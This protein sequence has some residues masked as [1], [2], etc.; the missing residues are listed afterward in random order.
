MAQYQVGNEIFEIDDAVPEAEAIEAINQILAQPR[1]SALQFSYDSARQMAGAGLETIGDLSEKYF[2]GDL[3]ISEYG[4]DLRQRAADDIAKGRYQREFEGSFSDQKSIGDAAGW[5]L[6]GIQENAVS[7]GAALAGGA[8]AAATA[9]LSLPAAAVIGGI[10]T[11]GSAILGT[12]ET[13]LEMR[14]KTGEVNEEL[15]LGTG[16][17]IGLLDR[18]GAGKVFSK[19]QLAD[20]TVGQLYEEL[21]KKGY[22]R[23]AEEFGKEVGKRAT[24]EGITEAT[25]EGAIVGATAAT[26]GEYTAGEV[27]DR[28]LDAGVIG[29]GQAGAISAPVQAGKM[30]VSGTQV[31]QHM[32]NMDKQAELLR[33]IGMETDNPAVI[34]AANQL[35]IAVEAARNGDLTFLKEIADAEQ[36]ADV[37]PVDES[38]RESRAQASF[39]A[40]LQSIAEDGDALTGKPLDLQDVNP[41]SEG[42][43]RKA[44]ETAHGQIAGQIAELVKIL[45]KQL[46]P[47]QADTLNEL[48]DR[49][50]VKQALKLSRNKVKKS[51]PTSAFEQLGEL[52]A[53][54]REGDILRNLVL[55]SMELT[56][57]HNNGYVGGLSGFVDK[58]ANPFAT[59]GSYDGKSQMAN[60]VRLA[61]TAVA[62]TA[63]G[64]ITLLAQLGLVGGSRAIDALSG[65]R[66]SAV[67][68][69]VRD[70]IGNTRLGVNPTLPSLFEQEKSLQKSQ[71][72]RAMLLEALRANIELDPA[73][74]PEFAILKTANEAIQTY[75][76]TSVPL[77]AQDIN[78]A[79]EAL[80]ASLGEEY[81]PF[82]DAIRNRQVGDFIEN[83]HM[84]LLTDMIVTMK[85][86]AAR[87]AQQNQDLTV[88]AETRTLNQAA[89]EA[90]KLENQAFVQQIRD[91]LNADKKASAVVKGRIMT[92]LDEFGRNLG[93]DPVKSIDQEIKKIT[94]GE[95]PVPQDMV[96][97][98]LTPYRNRVKRQQQQAAAADKLAADIEGK[99]KKNEVFDPEAGMLVDNT[100]FDPIDLGEETAATI[101]PIYPTAD[102]VPPVQVKKKVD[103]IRWL[104]ENLY[105]KHYGT[106]N[107]IE[108][109]PANVVVVGRK[110]A[111][112]ALKAL[113][114]D[115][116]AIGWYDRTLKDAKAVMTLLDP[117]LGPRSNNPDNELAFDFALAVTSNGTAV[118]QNFEYAYKAYQTWQKTGFM[119][120]NWNLGGERMNAMRNAFAFY[121][122]YT[123]LYNRG[124]ITL[125]IN[126]FFNKE[127]TRGELTAFVDEF[128]AT[129]NTNVTVPTKDA[130]DTIVNGSYILGPKIGQGF[131]QN[132]RGNYDNLTADMWWMRMWNRQIGRPFEPEKSEKD[133]KKNRDII[134]RE[135]KASKGNDRKLVNE[136]LK[137]IGETRDGLYNSAERID[138]LTNELHRVW[139]RYYARHKKET[140]RNPDKPQLWKTVGTHF[141]NMGDSVRDM[142]GDNA[143][144]KFM[145]EATREAIRLMKTTGVDISVAD[146]QAL[147]WYPEKR[148]LKM[149]GVKPGQGDDNDYL[150]AAIA[151]AKKEGFTNDQIEEALGASVRG[152]TSNANRTGPEGQDG[153]FLNSPDQ[154]DPGQGQGEF[155]FSQ[156]I[157]ASATDQSNRPN[158]NVTIPTPHEVKEEAELASALFE[159][160]KPGSP[161][162]FGVDNAK[163]IQRLIEAFGIHLDLYKSQSKMFQEQQTSGSGTMGIYNP[164]MNQG[165]GRMGVMEPGF[166]RRKADIFGDKRYQQTETSFLTTLLHELSHHIESRATELSYDEFMSG[167]S[168]KTP[169]SG[170]SAR[171]GLYYE[172][173]FIPTSFRD[174]I[175]N[176]VNLA[177]KDSNTDDVV[178][179][180][181]GSLPTVTVNKARAKKISAELDDL[182]TNTEFFFRNR[183]ELS[184]EFVR[185]SGDIN[186]GMAK[187]MKSF[188][189]AKAKAERDGLDFNFKDRDVYEQQARRDRERFIRTYIRDPGETAVDPL[190]VYLGN[191]QLAKEVM[192][193]TTKL[194]REFLNDSDL[195][196][197]I[198]TFYSTP[199]ATAVAAALALLAVNGP[200]GEEEEPM[201]PMSGSPATGML[202]I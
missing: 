91:E 93:T 190:W 46:D 76:G 25:Q 102:A 149:L 6:Q 189:D 87:R 194:I 19:S 63:T 186:R 200:G 125:S 58:F 162:E 131:Y 98:Y 35:N 123:D 128:N 118:L 78:D 70:N 179:R 196:K 99:G 62:G 117:T 79:N 84:A 110:M 197:G 191:P 83:E 34:D 85:R 74:G 95:T 160:G 50:D 151:L 5:V 148:L 61:G 22:R 161:Y 56:R 146:F 41:N 42:G 7:G 139:N 174:L 199:L 119:P 143:D 152:R 133:M 165:R 145:R 1:D 11:I 130:V 169:Q 49:S 71:Q 184:P 92:V 134:V 38:N 66:R 69:Y 88:A 2:G 57:V 107:P 68:S 103:A 52:T 48:F 144:R 168:S 121:N 136:A 27:G 172:G 39:A 198:L 60:A 13:A 114:Q 138:A 116:N 112:E 97:K 18:F 105:V 4:Q 181:D 126:D 82:Y 132:L 124:D 100:P 183:P 166:P 113:E 55:E 31:N 64:G 176:I 141:K 127:M 40:R 150:D 158:P 67:G 44:V 14:E 53:G 192:P 94:S 111:A 147:M 37:V 182:Q 120:T 21:Q 187:S 20:M 129:H 201:M 72:E 171:S 10:T 185:A 156:P 159:V 29:T 24:A 65:G 155:E 178:A 101:L 177:L 17:I 3:G 167:V 73:A 195:T 122:T 45:S 77:G 54:T 142:P 89:R 16:A 153:G 26:G 163:D 59:A 202:T 106:T 173:E 175:N 32:S 188:D 108:Y 164:Y 75:E 47:K 104:F 12:G 140:G 115:N 193:E 43:A 15:A 90:G 180:D 8:A 170:S 86:S 81:R 23:A 157:L 137:N 135:M 36:N 109:S 96:D 51:F 28:L 33:E 30:A 9:M 154:T 80:L